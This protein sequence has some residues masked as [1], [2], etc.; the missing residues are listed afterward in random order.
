M[1]LLMVYVNT[2]VMHTIQQH[3]ENQQRRT[4]GVIFKNQAVKQV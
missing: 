1:A 3:C 2:F 4:Q